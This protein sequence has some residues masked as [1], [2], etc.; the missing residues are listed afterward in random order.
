MWWS[1]SAHYIDMEITQRDSRQ[2]RTTAM[3]DESVRHHVYRCHLMTSHNFML[4]VNVAN[5]SS[6]LNCIRELR[7]WTLA[8]SQRLKCKYRPLTRLYYFC[9]NITSPY[10]NAEVCSMQ[11]RRFV[12]QSLEWE[13]TR[14][15]CCDKSS[16]VDDVNYVHQERYEFGVN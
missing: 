6:G 13:Q 9:R 10:Y 5:F 12:Q 15:N 14:G 16:A 11:L 7:T 2:S 3:S 8:E 1:M 4:E